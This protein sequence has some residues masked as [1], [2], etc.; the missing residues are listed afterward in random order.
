VLTHVRFR[1]RLGAYLDGALEAPRAEATRAHVA[2]CIRCRR[3]AD[4]F[5]RLG[6]LL[7]DPALTPPPPDLTGFWAGVVRRIEEAGRPAPAR[8]A[9][10]R[11]QLLWRP[12]LAFGGAL[13]AAML[14]GLTFWQA[15][16]APPPP[17]AAVIVRSARTELPGGTVMVY[18]PAE[19]DMA[20]VWVFETE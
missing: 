14:A 6:A 10:Y 5:R 11:W 12:R 3:E 13:A 19:Q 7:K 18:T 4:E 2:A 1:R 9:P 20:V 17:G 8:R 16:Y 15:F